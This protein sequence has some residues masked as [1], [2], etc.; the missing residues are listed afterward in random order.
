MCNNHNNTNTKELQAKIQRLET[1]NTILSNT[2]ADQKALNL[3][4]TQVNAILEIMR[5]KHVAQLEK[6]NYIIHDKK[7]TIETTTTTK[8]NKEA[9]T[10][11]NDQ[12]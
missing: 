12:I 1:S 6:I 9:E 7:I 2:L 3:N 11:R 8:L 4:L 10:K 5:F